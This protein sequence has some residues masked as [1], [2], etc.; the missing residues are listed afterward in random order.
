MV[1]EML[2]GLVAEALLG[3][4]AAL[5]RQFERELRDYM[6]RGDFSS[7]QEAPKPVST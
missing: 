2:F 5:G 3:S 4:P 1:L 6:E 7:P